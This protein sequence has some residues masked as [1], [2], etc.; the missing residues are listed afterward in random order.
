MHMENPSPESDSVVVLYKNT[1]AE[2]ELCYFFLTKDTQCNIA[3]TTQVYPVTPTAF[4]RTSPKKK[5]VTGGG[6]TPP[7]SH[8]PTSLTTEGKHKINKGGSCQSPAQYFNQG[9]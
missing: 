7:T 5:E 6:D 2:G 3:D 4:A 8:P 9:F 1:R